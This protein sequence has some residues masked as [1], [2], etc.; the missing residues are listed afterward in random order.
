[1]P[2]S[3]NVSAVLDSDIGA[4]SQRVGPAVSA[5]HPPTASVSINGEKCHLC[6]DSCW[7]RWH[8]REGAETRQSSPP[9]SS[10][11]RL[12]PREGAAMPAARPIP[13]LG[14]SPPG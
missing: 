10:K 5:R 4:L 12:A 1:M 2:A 11:P 13:N 6:R 8:R 7:R 9:R 14:K 3:V